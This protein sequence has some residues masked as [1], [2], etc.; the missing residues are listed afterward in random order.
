ML[1]FLRDTGYRN[2]ELF[3]LSGLS[4]T[5][6]RALLDEYGIKASARHVDVG[7]PTAPANLDRILAENKIL[8]LKYFGSGAT[9]QFK[10][11]AEWIAYAEYLDAVARGGRPE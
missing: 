7:T 2:I 8:G 11:E 1:A 10:T 4:A 6:M 3:T 5:Q 9:P